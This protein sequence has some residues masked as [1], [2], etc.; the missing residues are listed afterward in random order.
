MMQHITLWRMVD[1]EESEGVK[2]STGN[3]YELRNIV[4]TQC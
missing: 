3:K 4:L 2:E 1:Y